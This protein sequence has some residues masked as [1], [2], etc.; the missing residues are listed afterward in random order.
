MHPY[1]HARSSARRH[2]GRWEDYHP[3]HAWFDFTK[4]TLCHFTHRAL[5]HHAEGV[6][7][8]VSVFGTTIRNTDGVDV[9][10]T[11]LG[12]QHV[13]EDCSLAPVAA[14]WLARLDLPDWWDIGLAPDLPTLASASARHFGGTADDYLPLH[15]WFLAAGSWY[16]DNRGLAM[17]HHAFGIFQAEAR[18]GIVIRCADGGAVPVRPVAERHVRTALGRIPAAGD[19]LRRIKGER[20]MAQ[21]TS[22]KRLGLLR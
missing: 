5:H 15:A 13:A 6:A 3:L 4:T 9:D 14:D 20:W 11:T 19:F 17:R 1:D 7:E 22:P 21:A 16:P 2:G 12:Q 18:F 10:V 8:A